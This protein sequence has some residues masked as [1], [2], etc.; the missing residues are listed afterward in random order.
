MIIMMDQFHVLICAFLK[1][2]HWPRDSEH[3]WCKN[4][5]WTEGSSHGQT[6]CQARCLGNPNCTGIAY[7]HKKQYSHVCVQCKD[8]VLSSSLMYDH[9]FDF[10]R[11]PG[12]MKFHRETLLLNKIE[13]FIDYFQSSTF[14]F[15]N[16]YRAMGDVKRHILRP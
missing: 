15:C 8:D 14:Y 2:G 4:S 7:S 12:E 16:H 5:I 11:I 9:A 1:I 10:Y 6:N 3:K 13:L